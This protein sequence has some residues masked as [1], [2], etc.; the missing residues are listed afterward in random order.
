MPN[1]QIEINPNIVYCL[2]IELAFAREKFKGNKHRLAAL[3]EEVG[4]LNKALMEQEEGKATAFD[5][6]AE[7]IQ[8]AA[9]AIRIAEEGDKSFEKYIFT[10]DCYLDFIQRHSIKLAKA[11]GQNPTIQA[12]P[13]AHPSGAENLAGGPIAY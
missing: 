9:M 10:P 1:L 3:T 12:R 4:E 6:F 7:A 5:I 13:A 2:E 11:V 8:V